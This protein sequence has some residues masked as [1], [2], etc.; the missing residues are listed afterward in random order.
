MDIEESENYEIVENENENEVDE[1]AAVI[2]SFS[3]LGSRKFDL[4]SIDNFDLLI[5]ELQVYLKINKENLTRLLNSSNNEYSSYDIIIFG[6]LIEIALHSVSELEYRRMMRIMYLFK[7]VLSL[8]E[9]DTDMYR[10]I[11]DVNDVIIMIDREY[12]YNYYLLEYKIH[13]R[14][15]F[16]NVLKALYIELYNNISCEIDNHEAIYDKDIYDMTYENH[17]PISL[18]RFNELFMTYID[19]QLK[20]YY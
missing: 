4:K 2:S 8:F 16:F 6:L 20:Y 19:R 12:D 13:V 9:K 15:K 18:S 1:L 5:E 14:T 10:M 11:V 17:N 3:R 7:T